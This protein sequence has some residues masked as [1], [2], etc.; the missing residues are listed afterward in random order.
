MVGLLMETATGSTPG[1][2]TFIITPYFY[3]FGV[4]E[5]LLFQLSTLRIYQSVLLFHLL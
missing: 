3:I 5:R 1:E 2:P 4:S